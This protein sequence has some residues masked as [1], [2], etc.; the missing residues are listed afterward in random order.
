[1]NKP[2]PA[3][4]MIYYSDTASPAILHLMKVSVLQYPHLSKY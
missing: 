3:E 1:M 2:L 4:H